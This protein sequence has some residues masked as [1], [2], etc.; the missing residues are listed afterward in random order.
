[1]FIEHDETRIKWLLEKFFSNAIGQ[2]DANLG[3]SINLM[4]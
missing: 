3:M 4:V 2:K 1:M